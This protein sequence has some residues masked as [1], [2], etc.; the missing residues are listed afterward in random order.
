LKESAPKKTKEFDGR[1]W[2]ENQKQFNDGRLNKGQVVY[3]TFYI[4]SKKRIRLEY[5]FLSG[6]TFVRMEKIPDNYDFSEVTGI[7]FDAFEW[8]ELRYN[9]HLIE[10]FIKASEGE[11]EFT[12]SDILRHWK[13]EQFKGRMFC[14][15]PINDEIRLTFWWS[16]TDKS[17]SIDIRRGSEITAGKLTYWKGNEFGI[18]FA[19]N[20][21]KYFVHDLLPKVVN[22]LRMWSEMNNAGCHLWKSLFSTYKSQGGQGKRNWPRFNPVEDDAECEELLHGDQVPFYD[23]NHQFN[24]AE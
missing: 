23:V 16:Q 8:N 22:G 4:T 9:A 19:G 24:G 14:R 10:A 15:I 1:E 17:Y 3:P 12:V 21:C 7:K 2:I 20:S 5:N 18:C 13:I 6:N 11:G